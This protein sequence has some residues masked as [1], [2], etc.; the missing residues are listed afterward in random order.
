M[1][2]ELKFDTNDPDQKEEFRLVM[3]ARQQL[4]A[5]EEIADEIFRPARKHGY[6]DKHIEHLL[7]LSGNIEP[8]G[9]GVGTELISA[10][11]T[12]FYEI[13]RNRGVSVHE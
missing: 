6:K 12:K 2:I 8:E 5:L 1:I 11:E 10:L 3:Q 7:K 9:Y 4:F 13:L